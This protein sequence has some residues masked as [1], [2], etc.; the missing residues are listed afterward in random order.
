[1]VCK[2]YSEHRSKM[3]KDRGFGKEGGRKKAKA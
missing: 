2:E 3:A 1:L